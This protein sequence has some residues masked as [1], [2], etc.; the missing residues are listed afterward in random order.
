MAPPRVVHPNVVPE[1]RMGARTSDQPG[2]VRRNGALPCLDGVN[3]GAGGEGVAGVGVAGAIAGREPLLP[4]RGRSVRPR[5]RVDLALELLLE[6]IVADRRCGVESV[7]DVGL[8]QLG[9]VAGAHRT[10]R[11]DAGE[12]VGLQFEVDTAALRPGDALA[13]LAH[14]A[15]QVLH[16]VAVFVRDDVGLRERSAGRAEPGAQ[17]VEEAEVEI[18]V[19]IRRAVER[20]DIGRGIA[21]AG[22]D[23]V[24]EQARLRRLVGLAG[25]VEL[26]GPELLHAVDDADDSAVGACVGVGAGAALGSKIA[27]RLPV[28]AEA[29]ASAP[30]REQYDDCDDQADDPAASADGE[31]AA[32]NAGEAPTGTAFV[33]D[34][35]RVE[36]RVGAE[37]HA[38]ALPTRCE[39]DRSWRMRTTYDALLCRWPTSLRSTA[40]ASTSASAARASSGHI[41]SARR[42]S[43]A[44]SAPT[45]R[46]SMSATRRRSKRWCWASRT[47][48]SPRAG[49]T[50]GRWSCCVSTRWTPPGS[51]S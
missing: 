15:E 38:S 45:S 49:T 47:S 23:L 18:D 1:S 29:A 10:V 33:I 8:R 26:A 6:A 7:S 21:A 51:R 37:S 22:L 2:V 9:D 4:L 14:G 13:N 27:R 44:S 28:R 42:A 46:C 16:V 34:L 43:D 31:P 30:A 20:P 5:L 19:T 39:D 3:L 50:A 41:R 24:G 12:A 40:S 11:P 35:R 36:L 32:R 48:S 25:L 17:L